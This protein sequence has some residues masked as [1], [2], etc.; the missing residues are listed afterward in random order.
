MSLKHFFTLQEIGNPRSH[1]MQFILEKSER[2]GDRL[3]ADMVNFEANNT[4]LKKYLSEISVTLEKAYGYQFSE[5]RGRVT[6]GSASAGG[7][8]P[9]EIF[10][11]G[12]FQSV[13]FLLYYSF[14]DHR[15]YM[16][17]DLDLTEL[18]SVFTVERDAFYLILSAN[19]GRTIQRYGFR[20]YRYCL[21][22]AGEVLAACVN[23]FPG[24]MRMVNYSH[25][26]ALQ[27]WTRELRVIGLTEFVFNMGM[28]SS[29]SLVFP[30]LEVYTPKVEPHPEYAINLRELHYFHDE[31]IKTI[32][33]PEV[34]LAPLFRECVVQRHSSS[35]FESLDLPFSSVVG[36]LQ[37]L[38]F[39]TGLLYK[40][41]HHLTVYVC[42]LRVTDLAAGFYKFN[43]QTGLELIHVYPAE[44][45]QESL[46]EICQKQEIVKES[47]FLLIFCYKNITGCSANLLKNLLS[48]GYVDAHLYYLSVVKQLGNT[49]IGGFSDQAIQ[50]LI[51]SDEQ[52]L[53]IH[54]FGVDQH[55]GTKIDALYTCL[56]YTSPSPRDH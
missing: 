56:L 18:K 39:D 37:G 5:Q 46:F 54:A 22:D 21:I 32:K 3:S 10:I 7:M 14:S 27:K 41:Q 36:V 45:L 8:Y 23:V 51:Q 38:N 2:G 6:R 50:E 4:V 25:M 26:H 40:D 55:K 34:Q 24:E 31:T 49:C 33:Y 15:F 52:P 9:T 17:S 29:D 47:S 1:V 42:A 11:G 30:K 43:E 20:G 19:I 35:Q 28:D 48:L 13:P 44:Q 12:V 16:P 53:I